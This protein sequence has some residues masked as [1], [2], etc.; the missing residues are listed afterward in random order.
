MIRHA[1]E[2]LVDA[3][4]AAPAPTCS[5]SSRIRCHYESS[6]CCS[7]AK[8]GYA[9]L[10]RGVKDWPELAIALLMGVPLD[11]HSPWPQ[12]PRDAPNGLSVD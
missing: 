7:N 3:S 2:E 10:R 9:V 1:C 4:N 5:V 8:E 6:R 11:E 12:H